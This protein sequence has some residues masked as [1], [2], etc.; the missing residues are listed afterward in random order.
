MTVSVFG[1]IIPPPPG[2][3]CVSPNGKGLGRAIREIVDLF[4]AT[5]LL[6]IYMTAVSNDDEVVRVMEYISSDE[7]NKIVSVM[8]N[9]KEFINVLE[10]FCEDLYFDIYFYLNSLSWFL[11]LPQVTRPPKLIQAQSSQFRSGFHGMLQD[12]LNALPSDEIKKT[13]KKLYDEDEFLQAAV[14][15]LQSEEFRLVGDAIEDLPEYQEMLQ[16]LR[17]IGVDIDKIIKVVMDF[18]GWRPHKPGGQ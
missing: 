5:E 14:K 3:Q 2:N 1:G 12:L 10:Y 15:K 11:G 18:M 17:D 9:K 16:K 4:P 7:F 8:Q 13:Y 6:E